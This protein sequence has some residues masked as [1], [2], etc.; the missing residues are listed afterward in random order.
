MGITQ[1]TLKILWG[2]CGNRCA[3][4]KKTVTESTQAS[5]SYIIGENAHIEGEKSTAARYRE[6]MTDNER[7]AYENLVVLCPT[8]HTRID[9]T[10]IADFPTSKLQ[11]M[12]QIHEDSCE[13]ILEQKI[14]DTTYAELEVV[15]TYISNSTDFETV[16]FTVITPS[17]KITK[18]ALS[19]KVERLIKLGMTQT[20][21]V[22]N[23]INENI[24]INFGSRLRAYFIERYNI[25]V[26]DL[27][28]DA[29]FYSLLNF[30]AG[31]GIGDDSARSAGLVVLT[32]FFNK[33]DIFEK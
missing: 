6:D 4:C 9:K 3:I 27:K 7:N 25:E 16:D 28:G 21:L 32:Y 20:N 5:G 10:E 23:Y 19:T 13:R 17:E 11:E 14:I 2:R 18:N 29:L 8:C 30:A 22:E 24:D 15:L 31:V 33:C 26:V 1:E 12:K